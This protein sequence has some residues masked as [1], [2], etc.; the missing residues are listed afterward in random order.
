MSAQHIAGLPIEELLLAAIATAT[1]LIALITW[2][3]RDR[4]RRL[5]HSL[6]R[7]ASDD[8]LPDPAGESR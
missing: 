6:Q 3:I 4:L 1:P 2:E 7:S 8:P 5:R